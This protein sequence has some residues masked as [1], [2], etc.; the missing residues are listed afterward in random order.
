[1]IRKTRAFL[2]HLISAV[3]GAKSPLPSPQTNRKNLTKWLETNHPEMQICP[4]CKM[5]LK[6]GQNPCPCCGTDKDGFLP[7]EYGD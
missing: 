6:Y 7:T 1:M 5:V 3:I 2:L 4:T